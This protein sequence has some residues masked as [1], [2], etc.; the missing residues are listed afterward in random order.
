MET[1]SDLGVAASSNA[2]PPQSSV[3][4]GDSMR[5]QAPA[6]RRH[7]PALPSHRKRQDSRAPGVLALVSASSAGGGREPPPLPIARS[8]ALSARQKLQFSDSDDSVSSSTH[9]A[10]SSKAVSAAAKKANVAAESRHLQRLQR[11]RTLNDGGVE[12][13]KQAVQ[14]K[15][16]TRKSSRGK[17]RQE[18]IAKVTTGKVESVGMGR[19]GAE[20]LPAKSSFVRDAAATSPHRRDHQQHAQSKITVSSWSEE[21]ITPAPRSPDDN[22]V[23]A[24]VATVAGPCMVAHG[25]CVRCGMSNPL[26][27]RLASSPADASLPGTRGNPKRGSPTGISGSESQEHH[28]R[29]IA[30][31]VSAHQR[32]WRPDSHLHALGR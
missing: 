26:S 21:G 16:T 4:S 18:R 5:R 31:S 6:Q 13:E 7:P 25:T 11:A 29:V 14:R 20:K 15:Q 32:P 1:L 17:R 27:T 28:A 30:Q 9:S 10:G 22:L 24:P 8:P 19:V 2:K 3:S 23:A 12:G